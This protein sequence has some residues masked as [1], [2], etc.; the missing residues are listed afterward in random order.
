MNSY[1]YKSALR[2]TSP[3]QV[4]RQL[5]LK[6]LHTLRSIRARRR[7]FISIDG[8]APAAKLDVQ[9]SRRAS[10]A[11][12]SAR[13][14]MFDAQN[15][16]P[17]CLFMGEVEKTIKKLGEKWSRKHGSPEF[18]FV[19]SG[20]GVKEEGEIKIARELALQNQINFGKRLSRAFLTVDSDAFLQAFVYEIPSLFI[21]NTQDLKSGQFGCF[22]G[23]RMRE[24]FAKI[25][26]NRPS[27]QLEFA[28]LAIFSGNDCLPALPFGGITSIWSCYLEYIRLDELQ[29]HPFVNKEGIIDFEGI[30]AFSKFMLEFHFEDTNNKKLYKSFSEKRPRPLSTD[31]IL[32]YFQAAQWSLS[33]LAGTPLPQSLS[34]FSSPCTPALFDLANIN[35]TELNEKLRAACTDLKDNKMDKKKIPGAAAIMMLDP[36]SPQSS[37]YI[38][39]PLRSLFEEY[40]SDAT[41]DNLDD[42]SKFKKLCQRI[43]AIP[44]D[45][46]TA[47]ELAVTFPSQSEVFSKKKDSWRPY[48]PSAFSASMKNNSVAPRNNG[49]PMLARLYN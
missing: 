35:T 14:Q 16:T 11:M 27:V 37:S 1:L 28:L 5:E 36:T 22:S 31:D 4:L 43:L 38:A 45:N 39:Q 29:R 21:L 34:I 48:E 20:S 17:G 41:V 3:G 26:P 2:S 12:E 23:E 19:V 25:V 32:D 18:E 13:S 44:K 49:C 15:F 8:V 40:H 46:F 10:K 6:L 47:E 42:H 30:A 33:R 24:A 9:R 7:I